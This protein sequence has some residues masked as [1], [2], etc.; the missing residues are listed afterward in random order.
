MGSPGGKSDGQN[1]IGMMSG[2]H[3][4]LWVD[5]PAKHK[6]DDPQRPTGNGKPARNTH[7]SRRPHTGTRRGQ[8]DG[9]G[10]GCGPVQCYVH[11]PRRESDREVK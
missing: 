11:R 6:S 7:F 8:M 9:R 1:F 2:I 5:K 10:A 3:V 4:E